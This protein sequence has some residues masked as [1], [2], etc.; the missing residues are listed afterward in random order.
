MVSSPV[1]IVLLIGNGVLIILLLR[2]LNIGPLHT[3]VIIHRA[4][5]DEVGIAGFSARYFERNQ[6]HLLVGPLNALAYALFGEHDAPYHFI[7]QA[8]RVLEGVFLAGIVFR[9]TRRRLL[10][11][12]AGLA[13]MLTPIRLPELY[14]GI[15]WYI[16][17][18][19]PLLLA[20][21]YTYLLSL[22][23]TG[24]QRGLFYGLSIAC[25][26][27]S[28]LTYESGLPWIGVNLFV[29]WVA[30]QGT[31]W[32]SRWWPVL[33]D[34]LPA[35]AVGIA[36]AVAVLFVFDPWED[37]APDAGT[38]SPQRLAE[39]L[40]TAVTFP[41]LYLDRL[42]VTVA[43][44]YLGRIA[45][46]TLLAGAGMWSL[47]KVIPL[48]GDAA[49][50][51]RDF[52]VLAALAGV[53]L[54]CSVLVGTSNR[55]LNYVYTNRITFGRAAGITLLYVTAIFGAGR[56]VL[57][58]RAIAGGMGTAILLLGPGFAWLLTYQDYAQHMRRE[59]GRITDA[60]LEVRPLMTAPVHLVILTEPDWVGARFPD[61]HDVV[62]HE[63]QQNLWQRGGDAT[64]DILKAG[65]EGVRDEFLTFPGTCDPILG[66][67]PAGMCLDWGVVHAS[68]WAVGST[69]P[70]EDIVILHYDHRAGHMTILPEIHMADLT[71][72]NI[73]TAGPAVL[74]TNPAR[75][76]VP[77]A[78]GGSGADSY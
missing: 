23:R 49:P 66:E 20:S 61:A 47:A 28:V 36:L 9:L 4:W 22:Q 7:F 40:S 32:R 35:L 27:V 42:R 67:A 19:L 78:G 52:A 74:R 12:S 6:R 45:L 18:T 72:Y 29:G 46:V 2:G 30:R 43:D 59:I 63:V 38:A 10:A 75:L 64:L 21:T 34:A 51:A 31:P 65:N 13:L 3:D 55:N 69:H 37:L 54:L 50:F 1:W 73:T 53:M 48:N 8:S 24:W 60:I 77:L 26:T 11:V 39:Q 44:G 5:F 41:D 57:P 76:L 16:E 70:N 15:N 25:Y 71:E 62:I 14:Q 33:R 68:R 58:D 56:L 17:P